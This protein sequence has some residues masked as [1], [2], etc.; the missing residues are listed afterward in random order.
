MAGRKSMGP[1][2]SRELFQG[3]RQRFL[4]IGNAVQISE[5]YH[6]DRPNIAILTVV[7]PISIPNVLY[8]WSRPCAG[9]LPCLHS[10]ISKLSGS[11]HTQFTI[12]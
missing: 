8:I 7:E 2:T 4:Y 12:K 10:C 5:Q 1:A 3:A 9:I 6:D 11:P